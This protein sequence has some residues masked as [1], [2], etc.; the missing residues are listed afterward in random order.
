MVIPTFLFL[1]PVFLLGFHI[2][3]YSFPATPLLLSYVYTFTTCLP[4]LSPLF[5]TPYPSF[6]IFIPFQRFPCTFR[7]FLFSIHIFRP[8]LPYLP[9]FRLS[10]NLQSPR[11]LT[12]FPF[13]ASPTSISLMFPLSSHTHKHVFHSVLP[14]FHASFSSYLS[15]LFLQ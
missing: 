2:A 8:F 10:S 9:T 3:V 15:P 7:L 14:I 6:L 13:L 5:Y 11:P 4:I 1:F 12:V